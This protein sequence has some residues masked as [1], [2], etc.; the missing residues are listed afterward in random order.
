MEEKLAGDIMPVP[1]KLTEAV[2]KRNWKTIAIVWARNVQIEGE[3]PTEMTTEIQLE[4]V[5]TIR[6]AMA[7]VQKSKIMTWMT[8]MRCRVQI[9]LV[10]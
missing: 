9:R 4:R 3:M 6:E 1:R 2:V 8:K 10:K 5:L 7:T